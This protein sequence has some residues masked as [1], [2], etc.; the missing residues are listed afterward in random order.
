MRD[1]TKAA[2]VIV[3]VLAVAFG[4]VSFAGDVAGESDVDRLGQRTCE[5]A[6]GADAE[7]GGNIG[8]APPAVTCELS[9][10]TTGVTPMPD[11][12]REA[13]GIQYHNATVRLGESF[14]A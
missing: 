8:S 4:G 14:S 7:Y 3:A 13:L 1:N 9:D 6:F 11:R 2:L 10:G 5:A 12:M